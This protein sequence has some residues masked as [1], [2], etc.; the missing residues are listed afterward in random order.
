MRDVIGFKPYM[1]HRTQQLLDEDLKDQQNDG[2]I[3]FSDEST[4]YLSGIVNK[5]YCRIWAPNNPYVTVEAAM[6]SAKIN[7]WCAMSKTSIIGP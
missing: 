1:M 3:F 7:V 6:N 2:K 4:F 5:H